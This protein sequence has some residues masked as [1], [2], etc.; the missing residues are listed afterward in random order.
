MVLIRAKSQETEATI[1]HAW[2]RQAGGI[3]LNH[4]TYARS[5]GSHLT[6]LD[7]VGDNQPAQYPHS[8]PLP[9]MIRQPSQAEMPWLLTSHRGGF[10][11]NCK[12][13]QLR[14]LN[15]KSPKI[16]TPS[17]RK[18]TSTGVMTLWT[19][20]P[21]NNHPRLWFGSVSFVLM[22]ARHG[23]HPRSSLLGG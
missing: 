7:W 14:I 10:F 4:V 6:Q 1:A 22:M 9:S 5:Q 17:L 23:L 18:L 21:V 15:P 13:S 20:S 2:Q 11:L 8:F 16:L 12:V 19:I 3:P